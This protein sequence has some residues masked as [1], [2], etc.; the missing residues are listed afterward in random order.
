[1]KDAGVRGVSREQFLRILGLSSGAYDQIQHSIG[2]ALAFGS[3]IPA[4]PGRYL[5]IDL[6]A[7][8][9]TAGLAPALG[10]QAATI[11]VLG[12][13]NHWIAA[14]A[15]VDTD[16]GRH[17]FGLGLVL[18]KLGRKAKEIRITHGSGEEILSD[19][20][21]SSSIITVDIRDVVSRLRARGHA[22]GVDLS[23]PFFYPP[24]DPRFKDAIDEFTAERE[25]RVAR[26][27]QDKKKL[28]RHN[29]L[30]RRPGIKAVKDATPPAA[31]RS[32]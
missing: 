13:F 26:L 28:A 23:G 16:S 8:A 31:A 9:I 12:F 18:D 2:A 4:A 5:D 25:R 24:E 3:P 27:R 21:G 6:I 20:R 29:A 7:M 14:T 1:V 30:M 22:V 32:P 17:C 11:I 15:E 10:R 19:L